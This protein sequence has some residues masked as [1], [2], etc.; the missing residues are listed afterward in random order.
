M[1]RRLLITRPR[2][3]AEAFAAAVEAALPGRF[4]PVL[5]PLL[6]IAPRT[7]P[8]DLAG[9]QALLFSSA[10]GVEAF[11]AA[12]AERGLPALCVGDMTAE[13]AR[14]AG[15]AAE[16]AG[17]DVE[18]LARLALARARPGAGDLVHVRGVHAAG[19]L[20][21]RLRAA[22]AAARALELYEQVA[23]PPPP[24]AAAL[25]AAGG[26]SVATAFSP[27]S[28]ALFAAAARAA[29]WPLGGVT[30]VSLSAAADAAHAAPEPLRRVIAPRPDRAGMLAALAA[31]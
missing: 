8:V 4:A 9:A 25:L 29:G 20:V 19:D 22:G 16:S 30:L 11:A 15:L 23:V 1:A 31:L 28:A 17:G 5:A 18:A 6:A 24:D 14:A 10:N 26:V 21:G 3:Q 13:A 2:P 27:R 12:S 7:A